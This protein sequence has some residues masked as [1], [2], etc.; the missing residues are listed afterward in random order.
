MSESP[1]YTWAF[2]A[3]VLIKAAVLFA[4]INVAFALFNPVP[5]LGR[6]SIYNT[7]VAGRERLPYGTDAAAYTL[8]PDSLDTLFG[9]HVVSAPFPPDERR[10]FVFGDSST[11]GILLTPEQTLVGQLNAAAS[12]TN[13]T[14]SIQTRYYNLGYP[15]MS[16]TKDA[17]LIDHA[18]QYRP[19]AIIWI[20]TLESFARPI[21]LDPP[22]IQRNVAAARSL[23][24]RYGLDADAE[25]LALPTFWDRTLI[26]QRRAIAD[27]WRLQAFG[28]MW[29]TT[30]IDHVIGDYTR[31]SNDLN[32]ETDWRGTQ[33]A[34][35]L[36]AD[37]IALDRIRA[38]IETVDV[39]VTIINAPIF[40]GTG[41]Y[42]DIR[43]NYWYPRWAYDAYRAILAD[44][45]AEAGWRYID[46]WD[47]LPTTGFSDSPVHRTP[48]AETTLFAQIAP[49]L[50][51]D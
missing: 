21:Q 18:L 45:A 30:G 4:L 23:I 36:T 25:S 31:V 17:L 49:L 38:V 16:L 1:R 22:L 6:L 2:A 19:D 9:S 33:P 12:V 11:W 34:D 43:Y 47:A 26:G 14:R 50:S 3:R 44:A 40:R 7:L 48:D 8:S 24:E 51:D 46:L 32:P 35:G 37:D 20:V 15:I 27:W 13:A 39:P 28:W 5:A 10:V 42:S 29:N 41:T